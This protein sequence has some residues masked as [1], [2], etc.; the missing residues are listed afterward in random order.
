MPSE[1]T[2]ISFGE[3][4]TLDCTL[5]GATSYSWIREGGSPL[6]DVTATLSVE[7]SN[8]A[9][10][11][12]VGGDYQCV[13]NNGMAVTNYYYVGL[14]PYISVPLSD[15]QVMIGNEAVFNCDAV[16]LPTPSITWER[17]PD[18]LTLSGTISNEIPNDA[19]YT[20]MSTLTISS[21]VGSDYGDYICI[22]SIDEYTTNGA[23]LDLEDAVTA[24]NTANDTDI[25]NATLSGTL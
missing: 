22:A 18:T 14:A 2:V 13:A 8:S 4:V 19:T 7:Y 9:S 23:D 17:V 24:L 5:S 20:R 12:I 10:P 25:M 16:G 1:A 11:G 15:L 3:M 6:G 21:V